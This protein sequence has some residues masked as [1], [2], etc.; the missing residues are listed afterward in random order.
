MID[1][2]KM[3]KVLTLRLA[4]VIGPWDDNGRFWGYLLWAYI[5]H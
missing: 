3:F 5:A 4:D 1:T 2:G